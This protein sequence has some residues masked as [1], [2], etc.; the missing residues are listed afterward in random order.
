MGKKMKLRKL[1]TGNYFGYYKGCSVFIF[2][3][4]HGC[5]YALIRN[6][7]GDFVASEGYFG[8]CLKTAKKAK[9]WAKQKLL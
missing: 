6:S 8:T 4:P 2:R 7:K 9:E 5:F 3:R 1:S